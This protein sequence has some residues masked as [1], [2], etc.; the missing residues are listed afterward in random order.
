MARSALLSRPDRQ[1]GTA[2]QMTPREKSNG[3]TKVEQCREPR[4][5]HFLSSSLLGGSLNEVELGVLGLALFCALNSVHLRG[6]L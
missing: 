4:S 1:V 5:P 2:K 6:T 3:L